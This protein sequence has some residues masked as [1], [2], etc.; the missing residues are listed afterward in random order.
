MKK[1]LI[2][3]V[4][5]YI[6]MSFEK[7]LSQWP[8]NYSVNTVDTIG[9]EWIKKSFIGY[10]VIFHVAGLAHIRETKE[11]AD[12]YYKVNRD[13]V[14]E[15]ARKAKGDGGIFCQGSGIFFGPCSVYKKQAYF[16]NTLS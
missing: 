10:A 11:N 13:L 8:N 9:D 4:N 14:Y 7:W 16:S 15:V 3:G 1:I 5:S 6:G 12:L 2:T